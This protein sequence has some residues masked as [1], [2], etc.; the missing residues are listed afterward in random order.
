MAVKNDR[1]GLTRRFEIIQQ[2]HERRPDEL[3]T[4]N[5]RPTI[6]QRFWAKQQALLHGMSMS[7]FLREL[8]AVATHCLQVKGTLEGT[9]PVCKGGRAYDR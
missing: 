4:V 6:E 3:V 2:T 8:L 5:I 7:A 9:N 1:S